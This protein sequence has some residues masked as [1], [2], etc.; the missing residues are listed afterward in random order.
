ML[1]DMLEQ[2]APQL[3]AVHVDWAKLVALYS[4]PLL[5]E[6]A[7]EAAAHATTA[8]PSPGG[9]LALEQL[10]A[11]AP[12][13]RH[14]LLQT[15]LVH[16]IARVLRCSPAKVDV[17]QPLTKLGIDSL[18]AVELKNRVEASLTIKMPVVALL[19]GPTLA[20][21]AEA[22][23]A[24]GIIAH[25]GRPMTAPVSNTPA[26]RAATRPAS[27]RCREHPGTTRRR[28]RP[29]GCHPRRRRG[30][31]SL[32]RDARTTPSRASSCLRA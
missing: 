13:E 16:Q 20:T 7:R 23:I 2:D 10:H 4:P 5:S 21:L 6:M 3:M 17:H 28:G 19:K 22:A 1:A 29:G 8:P 32:G 15:F 31:G 11:A 12:E 9:G 14:G 24:W 26:D 30:A 18:M 25:A 27:S